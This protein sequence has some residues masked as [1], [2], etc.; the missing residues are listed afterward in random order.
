MGVSKGYCIIGPVILTLDGIDLGLTDDDVIEFLPEYDTVD[1]EGAQA[2]G[3][4]D[5]HRKRVKLTAKCTVK[6]LS[7]QNLYMLFDLKNPASDGVLHLDFQSKVTKRTL[8]TTG[9][10][11]NGGTRTH[12]ILVGVKSTGGTKYGNGDYATLEVEFQVY[13][14]PT[15]GR[16]GT[17]VDSAGDELEP[18]PSAYA[19]ING[20][21]ATAFTDGSTTVPNAATA[22]QVTFNTKIRPDQLQVSRFMLKTAD[23][24]THIP[25]T[26][27][28]GTTTGSTDFTKV[29]IAPTGG[30][31]ASE[32]YELI[33]APGLQSN[34]GVLSTDMAAVQFSTTA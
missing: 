12:T 26:V 18:A 32:D 16:F 17:I 14:D 5:T 27:T 1:L 9:L 4:I 31:D 33:I 23:G 20:G 15:L 11:P 2:I 10:G 13:V 30:F 21:T 29:V 28:H 22:I 3:I 34:E 8:V 24:N 7:Q 25:A 19:Y 6:E